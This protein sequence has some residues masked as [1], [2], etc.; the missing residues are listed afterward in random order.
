[1]ESTAAK[2]YVSNTAMKESQGNTRVQL[3]TQSRN[4]EQ[5]ALTSKSS[6]SLTEKLA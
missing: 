2:R 1:M 6:A 5:R 3:A 4:G